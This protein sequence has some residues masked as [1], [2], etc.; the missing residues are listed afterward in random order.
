MSNVKSRITFAWIAIA[1]GACSTG[2]QVRAV[3]PLSATSDAPYE[4]VLVVFLFSKFDPRRYLETEIVNE[5]SEM[6]INATASTSLMDSRTPVTRETFLKMVKDIDADAVMVSQLVSLDTKEKMVD[7]SP[8]ATYNLRP[9]YYYNVFS[10]DL[11]E[12]VQPMAADF[13]HSI[14]LGTQL[15]SV[16]DKDAVWAIESQTKI[17]PGLGEHVSYSMY[18]D[19]AEALTARMSKDGLIG[20]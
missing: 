6:G 11:Q 20:K 4:N 17:N 5:L 10:V 8:E 9:T 2:P 7:M 3:Q 12:Y 18:V 19:E 15:Y 14:L 16:R 1:M 13:K